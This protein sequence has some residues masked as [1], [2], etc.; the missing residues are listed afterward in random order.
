MYVYTYMHLQTHTHSHYFSHFMMD[1][2]ICQQTCRCPLSVLGFQWP[3]CGQVASDSPFSPTSATMG[4]PAQVEVAGTPRFRPPLNPTLPDFPHSLNPL[5]VPGLP[6][7]KCSAIACRS[8]RTPNV[9]KPCAITSL[10]R[11]L[12]IPKWSLD[13]CPGLI[14]G[15]RIQK[16]CL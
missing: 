1:L 13:G 11:K 9:R 12:R 2:K 4:F 15:T 14:Q 16:K 8:M 7:M 5:L 6:R 3:H 10:P